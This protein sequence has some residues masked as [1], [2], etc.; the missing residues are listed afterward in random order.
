MIDNVNKKN[1]GFN[2]ASSFE[3]PF[4]GRRKEQKILEDKFNSTL[5]YQGNCLL[6]TGEP[7]IGKTRLINEFTFEKSKDTMM[8]SIRV[9]THISHARELFAEI[10]KTYLNKTPNIARTITRVIDKKIYDEFAEMIPELKTYYP[11]EP[12]LISN[13]RISMNMNEIF[14]WFMSNLSNFAPVILII[15]DIHEAADDLRAMLKYFLQNLESLPVLCI[16]SSRQNLK[17]TKW[18]DGIKLK[19]AEKITLDTLKEEDVSELNNLLLDNDLDE[20]FFVWLSNRTKGIPLFIK[21]FLY[22]LFEKGIIYFDSRD[23]KWTVIESY[24]QINIPDTITETIRARLNR[25]SNQEMQFFKYASVIGEEFNPS[26]SIFKHPKKILPTLLKTAIIVK[27]EYNYAFSHPLIRDVIY[28]DIERNEKLSTHKKLGDYFLKKNARINAAKH[29]LLAENKSLRIIN[30]LLKLGED[31]RKSGNNPRALS[32]SEKAFS[33]AKSMRKISDRNIF[34]IMLNYAT[35]LWHIGRYDEVIGIS[36]E[37]IKLVKRKPGIIKKE[38]LARVYSMYAHSLVRTAR[39]VEAIK[40][41]KIG[42]GLIKKNKTIKANNTLIELETNRAFAYKYQW[43]TD[44]ALKLG[45]KIRNRLVQTSNPYHWYQVLNLLGSIYNGMDD[46][47]RAIQFRKKALDYAEK[48]QSEPLIASAKGNLGISLM[49]AGELKNG[50]ELLLKH[51]EYSIKTG[52]IRE[53]ALSYINLGCCYFYQGHLSKA[54]HEYLKGIKKCEKFKIEADLVWFYKFYGMLLIFKKDYERANEYINNGI[55]LAKKLKIKKS[56]FELLIHKGLLL[57]LA[58]KL[59]DLSKLMR[60]IKREF[61]LESK[62]QHGEYLILKGYH[63]LLQGKQESGLQEIETG[64]NIMFE[65]EEYV[66]LCRLLYFCGTQLLKYEFAKHRAKEYLKKAIEIAVKFNMNGWLDILQPDAKQIKIQP[67]KVFCLGKLRIEAPIHGEG[68]SDEWQWQKPKQLFSIFIMSI[69]KN[70]QL[71]REKIGALLWPN[72]AS[73]KI[74]NNFHVCLSQLK[75]VIGK[76]YLFYKS[77]VYKLKNVWIDAL[78]FKDLIHNG[79]A[80]INQGKIHLAEIKLKEAIGLY[81]GNFLEDS[82]D[83]WVDEI[84]NELLSLYRRALLML[85][86]V[87]LRKLRFDE[88]IEMGKNILNLD[89]FDEEGHR[90]LIRSYTISGEKA[91][92]INQYKKCAD[93]FQKELNCLPSDQTQKLYK[94]IIGERL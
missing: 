65:H 8:I 46:Y 38:K 34:D 86:E 85:G 61:A 2:P 43:Q 79:K 91:K 21:E 48:F 78:E 67:L 17:I 5:E 49:N 66:E 70:E 19:H 92:A 32:Y 7:G 15:E 10:V 9:K 74:T 37:I 11:Y 80:M 56:L 40:I 3:L 25:F 31:F 52:R 22:T 53:E 59:T 47:K 41:A 18:C 23:K 36:E 94:G 81:K 27:K 13:D 29:Y 82:Y 63:T 75:K 28:Q 20:S 87:C 76:E 93:L 84:R 73:S 77:G 12:K 57:Y 26:L 72:L 14:Y 42:I 44:K 64:I 30:L 16:L 89:P 33:M 90:F 45:L 1:P 62:T 54:E 4:I 35:G 55:I 24:S 6:I 71:N 69:L 88:A 39:Y 68:F 60:N 58:G 83:S 51:Q 50:E